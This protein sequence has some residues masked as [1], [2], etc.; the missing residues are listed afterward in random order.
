MSGDRDMQHLM[1]AL[2]DARAS[3]EG[4]ALAHQLERIATALEA[5]AGTGQ[6]TPVDFDAAVAF[7]WRG[8]DGGP[9]AAPLEPVAAPAL[10]AFDAL[11]NVERQVAI[12]ERN[13]RQFVRGFAANHVLTASWPAA[14]Q[15][16]RREGAHQKFHWLSEFHLPHIDQ[17][18]GRCPTDEEVSAVDTLDLS[19]RVK[20]APMELVVLVRLG[21]SQEPAQRSLLMR[22]IGAG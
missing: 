11:R 18:V 1:G 19:L 4:W 12:V 7:R 14:T 8:F 16:V 5:L 22:F 2:P 13:T 10:I 9:R 6:P 17:T 15:T 3:V 21:V 20:I